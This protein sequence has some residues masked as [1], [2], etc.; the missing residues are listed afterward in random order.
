[1]K[2]VLPWLVR[3]PS[4]KYYFSYRTLFHFISPHHPA[5]WAGSR[6]GSPVSESQVLS[7]LYGL[8]RTYLRFETNTDWI[9]T[10]VP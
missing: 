4:T 10:A 8:V 7:L 6:A 9:G 2:G 1:M 5:T 3:Q